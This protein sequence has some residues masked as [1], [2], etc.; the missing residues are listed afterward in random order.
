VGHRQE[1]PPGFA[2][3]G[4]ARRDAPG[5]PAVHRQRG[6]TS[7]VLSLRPNLILALHSGLTENEYQRLSE[8]APTVGFADR[9]WTSDWKE[10]TR[11]V[12]TAVG[13]ADEADALVKEAEAAIAAQ[14]AKHPEFAGHTFTYGW[15]LA[16]GATALDLYVWEDPRV[17][18]VE[19][20][21]LTLSP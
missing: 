15:Y 18:V 19:Q 16:D 1:A 13:K 7:Q 6:S 17:Q 2:P 9:A 5:D 10:L 21:G 8:I 11:T 3:G 4:R 12:G 14:A 20:L